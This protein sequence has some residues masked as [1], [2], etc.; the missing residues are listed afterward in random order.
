MT[1]LPPLVLL[2]LFCNTFY[3]TLWYEGIKDRRDQGQK[4]STSS[5]IHRISR[6]P[7]ISALNNDVR[8][9]LDESFAD[10]PILTGHAVGS[11]TSAQPGKRGKKRRGLD[12]EIVYWENKVKAADEEV[13]RLCLPI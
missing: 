5:E 3:I 1:E 6:G 12:D 13:K 2:F 10:L 4:M 7:D 8:R 9:H 11:S